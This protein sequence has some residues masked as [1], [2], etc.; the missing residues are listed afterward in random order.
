M[1]LLYRVDTVSGER[2]AL[3][4][5]KPAWRSYLELQSELDWLSAL[6]RDIDIGTHEPLANR[7]GELISTV[8][9]DGV[10]EPRHC[11]LFTWVPGVELAERLTGENVEK[12][13]VLSARLHEHAATFMPKGPFT[14]R[15]LDRLFPRGEECVLF[16]PTFQYLFDPDQREIF[17]RAMD[18][19]QSELD[20]FY[21]NP[22]GRRVI[23]GD[24][25]HENVKVFGGKLRP[26]DFEDVIWG[27]AIQDI[28]LTLY[29]FRYFT[30]PEAHDY[31]NL[32]EAFQ[33][34]YT[35]RLPWPKEYSGQI[36]TLQVARRIWVANW[37]LQNEDA[38]HH[39]TF[40]DRLA[41]SL[42]EILDRD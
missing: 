5:S 28:G 31:A 2:F 14:A 39:A 7:G 8:N 30:D 4:I 17:E 12:M 21:A 20:R 19:A 13:G 15:N 35:S 10:P 24:L 27:Y 6:A 9:V 36:D 40:V 33:R 38:Q 37:V 22:E 41:T 25:H 11:V 18:R 34:G 23:H 32:C 3:R 26:I 29:D 16:A 42:G 1:D